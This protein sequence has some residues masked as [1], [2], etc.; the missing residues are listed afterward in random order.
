MN[1]N[2]SN[3][4]VGR[5]AGRTKERYTIV[6][7]KKLVETMRSRSKNQSK[8]VSLMIAK[9]FGLKLNAKGNVISSKK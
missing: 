3:N 5:P 4:R 6:L 2:Q 1:T 8:L 7:D 9:H